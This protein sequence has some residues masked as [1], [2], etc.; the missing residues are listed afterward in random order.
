VLSHL[1]VG[2]MG[3]VGTI[4]RTAILSW[5][6][7]QIKQR[8]LFFIASYGGSIDPGFDSES[9]LELY[10]LDSKNTVHSEQG[11]LQK[12]CSLGCEEKFL[13]LSWGR[14]TSAEE[15]G[16][17]AGGFSSGIVKVWDVDKLSAKTSNTPLFSSDR[18]DKNLKGPVSALE[19]SP[20]ISGLLASSGA[21]SEFYIWDLGLSKPVEERQIKGYSLD[22]SSLFR[23]PAGASNVASAELTSLT[24]NKGNQRILATGH[25]SGLCVIWDLSQKRSVVSFRDSDTKRRISCLSWSP[26]VPVQIITGSDDDR[27]S[28]LFVWDLRATKVPLKDLGMHARGVTSVSWCSHDPNLIICSM[29]DGHCII[30]HAQTGELLGEVSAETGWN[31]DVQWSNT[32]PGLAS[33]CSLESKVS[34]WNV[35]TGGNDLLNNVQATSSALKDSF[36]EE[37]A[38]GLPPEMAL[39]SPH[40]SKRS[41]EGSPILASYAP[42]WMKRRSGVAF[43]FDGSLLY[44]G[45]SHAHSSPSPYSFVDI[46]QINT[47]PDVV[48]TNRRIQEM[49]S[50]GRLQSFCMEKIRERSSRKDWRTSFGSQV[51]VDIWEAIA[52]WCSSSP[53]QELLSRLENSL[54]PVLLEESPGVGFTGFA[55]SPCIFSLSDIVPKMESDASYNETKELRNEALCQEQPSGPAPWELNPQDEA[56]VENP[57]QDILSSQLGSMGIQE[58]KPSSG[59]TRKTSS[60]KTKYFEYLLQ[61]SLPNAVD[62]AF[63][64]N[65]PADALI[66]ASVGGVELFR[67]TRIKYLEH[68]GNPT[69]AFIIACVEQEKEAVEVLKRI[70]LSDSKSTSSFSSLTWREALA[71]ILN[72]APPGASFVSLCNQL[73]NK[74]QDGL[75]NSKGAALCFLCAGNIPKLSSFWAREAKQL[76]HPHRRYRNWKWSNIEELLEYIERLMIL[77]GLISMSDSASLYSEELNTIDEEA[78]RAFCD[79]ATLLLAEGECHSALSYLAPLDPQT[80]GTFGIAGELLYRAYWKLGQEVASQ[81]GFPDA[82]PFPF[83]AVEPK[84]TFIE[85]REKRTVSPL[86]T[87]PNVSVEGY[88]PQQGGYPAPN[89]ITEVAPSVGNVQES[90]DIASRRYESTTQSQFSNNVP[91]VGASAYSMNTG[92]VPPPQKYPSYTDA[93]HVPYSSLYTENASAAPGK[94]PTDTWRMNTASTQAPPSHQELMQNQYRTNVASFGEAAS[95]PPAHYG[96][97]KFFD[98]SEQTKASQSTYG[99]PSTASAGAPPPPPPNAAATRPA[100]ET[101]HRPGQPVISGTLPAS[102]STFPSSSSI[103]APPPPPPS[104]STMSSKTA[105]YD[106]RMQPPTSATQPPSVHANV[107]NWTMPSRF[108]SSAETAG[109][110]GNIPSQVNRYP[111]SGNVNDVQ[112]PKELS[113]TH[114]PMQPPLHSGTDATSISSPNQRPQQQQVEKPSFS[115]IPT[116]SGTLSNPSTASHAPPRDASKPATNVSSVQPTGGDSSP[117]ARAPSACMLTNADVSKVPSNYTTVVN[118]LRAFYSHCLT[119]NQQPIYR[120]KLEDVNRKLGQLVTKMNNGELEEAVGNK[121]IE[122]CKMLGQGNYDGASKVQV[123]LTQQHWEG[124]SSWIIALKRLIEAGKTGS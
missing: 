2:R 73:G 18:K 46:K 74:V 49:L 57:Q 14:K 39:G 54:P 69:I 92:V 81:F 60:P 87:N 95:P 112:A 35:V 84:R 29:K 9:V 6:P 20:F 101:L 8:D 114:S 15:L 47:N 61:G 78:A 91:P 25:V 94:A 70:Q 76:P 66:L 30:I 43:G 26:V 117:G 40:D 33:V 31:F 16:I 85:T 10:S 108:G 86:S 90:R 19:F 99:Q 37:F 45:V 65:Q 42:S 52:L 17:V 34:I 120:R 13:K 59:R 55:M 21:D 96:S 5:C 58:D 23:G 11:P 7:T 62:A 51:F 113:S 122:L 56:N 1:V 28:S 82:P 22:S 48:S 106:Q 102:Q 68:Q 123:V 105:G 71:L 50:E 88:L 77:R 64:D 118:T 98:L 83:M 93:G 3:L 119:L 103:S 121:L 100:Q 75:G 41:K 104:S 97:Y 12:L 116:S 27:S 80:Q 124:N 67:S 44:F 32:L 115:Q 36:G 111:P 89:S 38:S 72:Y 4:D 107:Q 79:Y 24:W 53:R 110:V 63:A 109:T